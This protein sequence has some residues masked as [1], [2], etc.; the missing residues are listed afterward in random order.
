M[1]SCSIKEEVYKF[2]ECYIC[3]E[4]GHLTKTCPKNENGIYPRGGSCYKCNEKTHLARDC[5][6]IFK[7][8]QNENVEPKVKPVLVGTLDNKLSGDADVADVKPDV[9]AKK[10]K[11]KSV[12]KF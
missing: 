10:G 12:V 2:A 7:D 3:K 1:N 5:P 6:K 9:A 4:V 8:S 11:R